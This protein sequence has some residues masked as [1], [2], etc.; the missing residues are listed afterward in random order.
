[1]TVE[2]VDPQGCPSPLAAMQSKAILKALGAVPDGVIVWSPVIDGLVE[3]SNNLGIMT[4]EGE[5]LEIDMLTRSS[6]PG[7][8]EIVQERAERALESS[9]AEIELQGGYPGWEADMT[10]ELL[11]QARETFDG[12]FEKQPEI[13]AI[14][15]GLECGLLGSML[16]GVQMISFGPEIR[17][18]HTPD[19][20]LVLDTMPRFWEFARKLVSDLCD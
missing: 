16:P 7:A 12:L 8:I 6:K 9:G 11:R 10:T 19:E 3:T 14:H 2:Q 18:A 17:A 20:A 1:V 13:K 5:R 15:A 4:T